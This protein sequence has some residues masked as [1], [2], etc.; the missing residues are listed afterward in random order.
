MLSGR[1]CSAAGNEIDRASAANVKRTKEEIEADQEKEDEFGYTTNKV[2]K[3][4]TSLG[5][6]VLSV[7][8]ER[9]PSGLGLSLAGHRDRTMMAV[10][11]CGMNPSGAAARGGQV[12]VGDEILEVNGIVL[13]GRCHLNASAIIKGLTG[14]VFK[15]ILLRRKSALQDV[16]VKPITQF[17]VTLSYEEDYSSFKNV[18]TITIKKGSQSLGIMI[19]EGRHQE[20]GHGIFVSDI[21][22]GSP[23]QSAGLQVGDMIL[24]VNKDTL[25]GCEYATA[26]STLKKTEGAVVLTVCNPNDPDKNANAAKPPSGATLKAPV[27]ADAVKKES[28]RAGGPASRPGPSPARIRKDP[29]VDPATCPI[30]PCKETYIE[31]HTEGKALGIVVAG[32]KDTQVTGGV[33][34]HEIYPDGPAGKDGRLKPGD[35]LLE[36]NSVKMVPDLLHERVSLAVK[37]LLPKM[38][39]VVFRSQPLETT[40]IDVQLVKKPGKGLGICLKSRKGSPGVYVSDIIPGSPA[41]TDGRI[42][43]LDSLTSVNGV[44]LSAANAE[45]CA[46]TLKV[47]C[48]AGGKVSLVFTRW[49]PT[50]KR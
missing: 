23:A 4:Y 1:T 8:L 34:V 20:V 12:K 45:E 30:E 38:R 11:V 43:V 29:I 50:A 3:K 39:M 28:P 18:R 7:Q 10:F 13:H 42:A 21:Q 33:V 40:T 25:L 47:G 37:Q 19:I 24:A 36:V 17:P 44:D 41:D 5:D 6:S 27:A 2:R 49:K 9:G 22:D 48:P 46:A 32:G 16:A 14:P 35:Q 26:A 15:L 31:I